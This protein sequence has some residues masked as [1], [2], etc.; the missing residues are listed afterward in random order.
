MHLIMIVDKTLLQLTEKIVKRFNWLTGKD[1]F[2]LARGV[3]I[4]IIALFFSSFFLV[5]GWSVTSY[6]LSAIAIMFLGKMLFLTI[7]LEESLS[8]K[9]S[10]KGVKC[11][12]GTASRIILRILSL[13]MSFQF[14][15]AYILSVL[16]VAFQGELTFKIVLLAFL[17]TTFT[18]YLMAINKP[19]FKR[20]EAVQWLKNKIK[21]A[22]TV[23]I[24]VPIPVT[25]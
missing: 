7:S 4:L 16:F 21:T 23:P 10:L 12:M 1:N 14:F 11:S 22:L 5:D 2:Y 17:L 25:E 13:T 6:V 19:P 9:E 8:L 3:A 24:P 20:S 15:I 18:F